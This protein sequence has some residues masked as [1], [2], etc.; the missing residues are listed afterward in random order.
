MSCIPFLDLRSINLR[1]RDAYVAAL[2][3]VL[4]SG[5]LILGEEVSAFE[6]EFAEWCG[7]DYCVGVSNG[8][9]ALHLV[10]RA[11][12]VGQGD[13]V[14]VPSHTY[15]ATWLA[16]THCGARP[17]PVEPDVHTYNLNPRLLEAAIT[18]RTKAIIAVHLYGQTADMESVNAFAL[19]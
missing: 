1:Q 16:V 15:I 3:R 4:E 18:D 9:E 19:A 10:L 5:R 13:E 12:G 11:W 14:I 7:T 6:N 8:L 2:H 17:V